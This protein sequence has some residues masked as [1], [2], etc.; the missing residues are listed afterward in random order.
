MALGDGSFTWTTPTTAPGAGSPSESVTFTPTDSTDYSSV[1]ATVSVTVSQAT[2]TITWPTASGITYGQTLAEQHAQQWHWSVDGSF[3]WTAQTTVPG[4]GSPSESVTF[5]PADSTDYSSV[6]ATVS[7]TVS[8]ATPTITSAHGQ[9]HHL[10]PDLAASTLSGGTSVDGSFTWTTPTTAPGAG[11]P[12]E[13]VTFT[14]TDSTDYSSVTATVSVTV[15]QA[16]P[17]ITS[18]HGQRHYLRPD[19]GRQHAQQWHRL[20]VPS[21]GPLQRRPPVLV[22]PRSP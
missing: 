8:Q 10:R 21:P 5:T 22:A 17:N 18:A 11:S 7:V 2:P 9:R 4:A 13:S 3:T 6:T 16:T 19:P 12:S 15:S 14:P 1:T 20:M